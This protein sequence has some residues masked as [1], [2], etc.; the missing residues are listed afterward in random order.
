MLIHQKLIL[1]G[2][3]LGAEACVKALCDLLCADE[4]NIRRQQTCCCTHHVSTGD[5]PVSRKGQRLR[6]RM[7]ASVRA[8]AACGHYGFAAK[9]RQ[10]L[11]NDALHREDI[12]LLL[13]A[14][15]AAA[16]IG[17]NYFYSPHSLPQRI[18]ANPSASKT[19]ST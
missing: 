8:A 3:P 7:H 4:H 5:T 14:M 13:K 2:F 10:H 18:N 15:I 9:L 17:H 16:I 11:L 6:Q 1:I 12:L 19:T